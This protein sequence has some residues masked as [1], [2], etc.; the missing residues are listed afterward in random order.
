MRK[1]SFDKAAS[2]ELNGDWG[3]VNDIVDVPVGSY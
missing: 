1:S 3:C 2:N